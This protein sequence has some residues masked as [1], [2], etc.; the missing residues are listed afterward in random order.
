MREIDLLAK[1]YP[2]WSLT[3]IREMTRTERH[4]WLRWNYTKGG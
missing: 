4:N 2:G 1:A 3:E